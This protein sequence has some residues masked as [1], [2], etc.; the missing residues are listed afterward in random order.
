MKGILTS[1]KSKSSET[2]QRVDMKASEGI[3]LLVLERDPVSPGFSSRS[4]LPG[5]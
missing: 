5:L 2:S 1:S 3:R 4:F